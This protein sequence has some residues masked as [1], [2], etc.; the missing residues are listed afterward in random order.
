MNE[1]SRESEGHRTEDDSRERCF[2]QLEGN[3][4]QCLQFHT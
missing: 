2:V 1:T 4:K 3:K